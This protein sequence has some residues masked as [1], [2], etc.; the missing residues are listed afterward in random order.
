MSEQK[1]KHSENLHVVFWLI[2]DSFWMMEWKILATFMIV[3]TILMAIYILFKSK[4]N[5]MSFIPNAAVLCWILANAN[6]MI[7][8]FYVPGI[9]WCSLIPFILGMILMF[10]Y[11]FKYYS[12]KS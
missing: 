9:K 11:I 10:Y 12:E 2:K 7:D 6:W 8:E 5:E 4:S 1:E 3:P